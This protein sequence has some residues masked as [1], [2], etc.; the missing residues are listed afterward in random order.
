M[1][2]Q[3]FLGANITKLWPILLLLMLEYAHII[4]QIV[5]ESLEKGTVC[6][7]SEGLLFHTVSH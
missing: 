4:L 3:C 2:G 1:Q 6:L 5:V 7:A